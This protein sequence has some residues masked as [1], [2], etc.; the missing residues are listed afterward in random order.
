MLRFARFWNSY[1]DFVYFFFQWFIKPGFVVFL[2]KTN[3]YR[4]ANGLIKDSIKY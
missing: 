1:L 4:V 3:E 2:S